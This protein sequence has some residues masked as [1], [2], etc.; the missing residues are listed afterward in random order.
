MFNSAEGRAGDLNLFFMD[1][2]VPLS[3]PI[4]RKVRIW[5][6]VAAVLFSVNLIR[7]IAGFLSPALFISD[8]IPML[9]LLLACFI[10]F[11]LASN[12]ATKTMM[13]AVGCWQGI[14]VFLTVFDILGLFRVSTSAVGGCIAVLGS[15][16]WV[17]C[18]AVIVGNNRLKTDTLSWIGI[19]SVVFSLDL[20]FPLRNVW[21]QGGEIQEQFSGL[22]NLFWI[23][24][25]VLMIVGWFKFARSEAF[26]GNYNGSPAPKGAYSP[27]NKYVVGALISA[28]VTCVALCCMYRY[29]APLLRDL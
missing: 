13:L 7:L 2:S 4:S 12:K 16:L 14:L 22:N 8:L 3:E 6:T 25:Y 18:F 27:L 10:L 28:G 15:L 1:Q 24:C 20:I 9:L 29:M 5:Q 11:R 26:A 21:I 17:F 19:L 23:M